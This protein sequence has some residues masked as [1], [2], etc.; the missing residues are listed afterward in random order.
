MLGRRCVADLTDRRL[1]RLHMAC[2][3]PGA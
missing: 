1:K 2:G 3:C